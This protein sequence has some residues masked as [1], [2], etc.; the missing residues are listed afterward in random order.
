M[1]T[2]GQRVALIGGAGFIGHHLALE[3]AARGA[4]VSVVDS[5]E[6]NHLRAFTAASPQLPRRQ[7]YLR[8]LG[9][10]LE[11]LTAAGVTLH[12]QD[13][14]DARGVTTVLASL[15]P[16]VIVHLAA[17]AHAGQAN[18]DP[19]GAF[20][21]SLQTLVNTLDWARRSRVE[22][23]VFMSS[24]MVY[25]NFTTQEA[26][27]EHPL[28]PVG[29]YG[30]MKVAAEKIVVAHGQVFDLPYSIV[31]PS[32]LYG[33]RCVSRRVIQAFIEAALDGG[34]L[35]VDADPTE[36]ID[37]TYVDDLVAGLAL[38]IDTPAAL[39]ETFN[40]TC[41]HARQISE[42]VALMCDRFPGL[43]VKYVARDKLRSRRGTLSIDKAAR[44]LGYRPRHEL[45]AG[46]G[47]YLAWYATQ[48]RH[49]AEPDVPA[50]A[51]AQALA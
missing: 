22:R 23:F 44:L 32:A 40:L 6:V 30:A 7:A 15:E 51:A 12:Q 42:L 48:D 33:P 31:R 8:M 18:A 3:L 49:A 41:G 38:V 14:R 5:L 28:A 10:R 17:V 39:G 11:L 16:Q 34:P 46:L 25:G 20:A 45:E 43:G 24:S 37:F 13:V 47:K 4:T 21:H 36:R 50:T 9:T 1:G 35:V 26:T 19:Q 2:A 27:E 29:I